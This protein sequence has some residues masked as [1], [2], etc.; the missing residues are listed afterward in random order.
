M[1]VSFLHFGLPGNKNQQLSLDNNKKG[2]GKPVQTEKNKQV[3]EKESLNLMNAKSRISLD[4]ENE[5]NN[6]PLLETIGSNQMEKF[7]EKME[8]RE[9]KEELKKVMK[10]VLT[11][12]EF[13]VICLRYGLFGNEPKNYREIS[14]EM[15][16]KSRQVA[17][18]K[19]K[20]A[21]KKLIHAVRKNKKL[22]EF[23]R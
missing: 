22:R 1:K 12:E 4:Y 23:I 21:M 8:K 11:E 18:Q 2:N 16:W 14:E 3:K 17:H 20:R 7:Q 13:K 9:M 6:L 19:E 10:R 15:G 5:E